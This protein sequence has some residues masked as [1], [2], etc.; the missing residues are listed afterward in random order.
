MSQ[1]KTKRRKSVPAKGKPLPNIKGKKA[2]PETKSTPQDS[3]K[4]MAWQMRRLGYSIETVALYLGKGTST[5]KRWDKE[6][7]AGFSDLPGIQAATDMIQTMIPKAARM[8]D[9]ALD[10]GLKKEA[11][12][13]FMRL[14][15]EASTK[16]L[17]SH[18][19]LKDKITLERS[20]VATEDSELIAEA[21]SI[22]AGSQPK[23]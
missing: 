11:S 12:E 6:V 10:E 5:I 7:R 14:G 23:A 3:R 20:D 2:P 21:K 1:R 13:K 18:D 16:V 8:L 17:I 19:I 22:I 4:V 9:K 15:L